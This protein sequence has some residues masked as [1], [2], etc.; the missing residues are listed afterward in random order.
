ML[1]CVGCVYIYICVLVTCG[2]QR[3]ELWCLNHDPPY[4]CILLLNPELTGIDDQQT[5]GIYL[6]L[7]QSSSTGV[8]DKS[9][10][11]VGPK[12]SK[13]R[14]SCLCDRHFIQ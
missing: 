8:I 7:S 10:F 6:S 13:L 12:R 9:G 5:Q 1:I 2:S 14:S 3:L 11:Y 4:I